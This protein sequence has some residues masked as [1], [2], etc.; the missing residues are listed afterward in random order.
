MKEKIIMKNIEMLKNQMVLI[1]SRTE[2]YMLFV[3][4]V[5]SEAHYFFNY[6][7]LYIKSLPQFY[8]KNSWDLPCT[9]CF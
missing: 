1:Q 7:K 2:F 3:V 4:T 5:T 9:K 8:I 6:A